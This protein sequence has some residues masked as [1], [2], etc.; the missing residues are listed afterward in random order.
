MNKFKAIIGIKQDKFDDKTDIENNK[1]SCEGMTTSMNALQDCID[2]IV[3]RVEDLK[4]LQVQLLKS[5]QV[6]T[7]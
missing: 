4:T 5:L 7:A 6:N 2:R 3:S 1:Q